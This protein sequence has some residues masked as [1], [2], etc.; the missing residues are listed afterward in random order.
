[1][2]NGCQAKQLIIFR[3]EQIAE[4]FYNPHINISRDKTQVSESRHQKNYNHCLDL[5]VCFARMTTCV[6]AITDVCKLLRLRF[7][8]RDG[9][10]KRA[11]FIGA[12]NVRPTP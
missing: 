5:G 3:K 8:Y 12:R 2:E 10:T 11:A 1:V 4:E 6:G 9:R 7:K